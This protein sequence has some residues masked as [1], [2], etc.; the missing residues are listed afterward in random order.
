MQNHFE[1]ND[2]KIWTEKN[3]PDIQMIAIVNL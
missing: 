3:T 1:T 2:A